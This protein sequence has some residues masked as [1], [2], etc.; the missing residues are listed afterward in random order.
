MSQIKRHTFLYYVHI[1]SGEP[2]LSRVL[3]QLLLLARYTCAFHMLYICFCL[4]LGYMYS[5]SN[6][7]EDHNICLDCTRCT[8]NTDGVMKVVVALSPALQHT[9]S[10]S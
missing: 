3:K 5:T 8:A 10:I 6:L 2:S 7:I 9:G 1:G 4:K